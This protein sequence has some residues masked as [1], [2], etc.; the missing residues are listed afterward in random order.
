MKERSHDHIEDSADQNRLIEAAYRRGCHQAISLLRFFAGN[1]N[2]T[3]LVLGR[4]EE[5]LHMVRFD[6]Q[7][8]PQL[9]H[10]V[11]SDMFFAG[12]H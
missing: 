5:K 8:H 12:H 1:K 11:L 2:I 3:D 9:L 6:G 10:E 7:P 4:F